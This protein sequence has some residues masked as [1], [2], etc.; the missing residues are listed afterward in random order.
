[1]SATRAIGSKMNTAT[2][3]F[4]TLYPLNRSA[5]AYFVRGD[6]DV[7]I[8]GPIALGSV[9]GSLV[10]ARLLFGLPADKLRVFFVVVLVVLAVQMLMTS[11]GIHVFG[12]S[13]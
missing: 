6:I 8:A 4:T 5:S 11:F 3:A 10:G 9:I 12:G 2:P 13:A 7:G 1:M